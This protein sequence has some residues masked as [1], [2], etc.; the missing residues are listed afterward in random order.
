MGGHSAWKKRVAEGRLAKE[1]T[2]GAI[3]RHRPRFG[4]MGLVRPNK[5]DAT[6]N[7]KKQK[8]GRRAAGGGSSGGGTM[9]RPAS[10]PSSGGG[11]TPQQ[12]DRARQIIYKW[13]LVA[14][15][16]L[17]YL[18]MKRHYQKKHSEDEF[19]EI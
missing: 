15:S 11:L 12:I 1:G 6:T 9:S 13:G 17:I 10:T 18:I 3:A 16:G 8:S 2:G 7:P 5:K 19:P 14:V 4:R